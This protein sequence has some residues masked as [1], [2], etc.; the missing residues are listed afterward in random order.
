MVTSEVAIHVCDLFGVCLCPLKNQPL[1]RYKASSKPGPNK[2]SHLNTVMWLSTHRQLC[3]WPKKQLLARWFQP[4]TSQPV[5]F[6]VKEA[7]AVSSASK[8]SGFEQPS[9][10]LLLSQIGLVDIW[11][12]ELA[13]LRERG[14]TIGSSGSSPTNVEGG[15]RLVKSLP[16]IFRGMRFNS[17]AFDMF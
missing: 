8:D 17:P 7:I 5:V 1:L 10:M 16:A 13:K 12:S 2:M 15:L 9:G 6:M 14:Q 4:I 3:S 11:S